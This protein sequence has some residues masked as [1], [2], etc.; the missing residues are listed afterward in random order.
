[1]AVVALR[2]PG[3]RFETRTPAVVS[4]LPRM[5]VAGFVG[6]APR[7][8]V[9]LPIPVEDVARFHDIFGTD[10]ALANDPEKEAI[11]YAELP[12]AV[13]AFFRNGGAR[14]WIVRVAGETA[15]TNRFAM[16][17]LLIAP[18]GAAGIRAA[19][20]LARSPGSWSDTLTVNGTLARRPLALRAVSP[21]SDGPFRAGGLRPGEL[22]QFEFP[23]LP[24][25]VAFRRVRGPRSGPPREVDLPT[26]DAS[27]FRRATRADVGA[28]SP[29]D[30]ITWLPAP[31]AVRWMREIH[32]DPD[33]PL[34]L[35][36]WGVTEDDDFV[37]DLSEADA[38]GL[39]A[40]SWIGVDVAAAPATARPQLLMLVDRV[41]AG[42]GVASPP[43]AAAIRATARAW[44]PLDPAA[45]VLATAGLDARAAVVDLEIWVNDPQGTVRRLA[46]LGF[47]APHT[48]YWGD[49]PDD[50]VAFQEEDERPGRRDR[51]APLLL[52]RVMNPR[53][54]LAPPV[55]LRADLDDPDK[56][57]LFIPLGVPGLL[58]ETF[59]QAA[60]PQS[61]DAL[62]RD[63][64]QAFDPLLFLDKDLE[65]A[66][67]SALM[68][69]AFHIQYV[70]SPSGLDK[71]VGRRLTGIHA[72][73]PVDE[74]SMIAVPDAVQR[75][76]MFDPSVIAPLGAPTL[77]EVSPA[78][79]Q[80]TVRWTPLPDA[81]LSYTLQA[82]FDARF[83]MVARAWDVSSVELT[84]PDDFV[85][86]CGAR[87]FYR[88]RAVSQTLGPGPWSNTGS[89]MVPAEPFTFCA[90]TQ[91]TAP[92]PIS[93]SEER[94]RVVVTWSFPAAIDVV[95]ALERASDPEFASAVVVYTGP[96]HLH[97]VLRGAEPVL[98]FR[99][100]AVVA[101]V[102]SPWSV[103]AIAGVIAHDSYTITPAF[104]Y[105][106]ELVLE[107]H[108]G[109]IRLCAAR[110][111]AHAVLGLPEHFRE[112]SAAEYI[113]KLSS[114]LQIRDPQRVLSYAA[115]FHP[116]IAVRETSGRPDLATWTIPPDGAVCGTIA[117][118]TLK[119]GAWY[120]PANQLLVGALALSP[121][122]SEVALRLLLSRV[123][124]LVQQ[125]RGFVAMD[126]LTLHPGDE[127]GELHVRRLLILLRRLALREGA[128]YVFRSNDDALRRLVERQF[129]QVL[130]DLFVRGAF[131]G[132]RH[133]EGYG[134]VA[135]DTVNTR[136]GRDSGRFVV[137]LRVAPSHPMMF[138]TV[139]LVQE[140]GAWQASEE[141]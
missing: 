55:R 131:A 100:S 43:S 103:T 76:W 45:A 34:P 107:V 10:L 38:R 78:D 130:G 117:A 113:E 56:A 3:I 125:P 121:D 111:D 63:G 122:L 30:D 26:A 80:V 60:L 105:D 7:G 141:P 96:A 128:T 133:E 39:Q 119:N 67:T 31:L 115:A 84:H 137:E 82:S 120:S 57:P 112:D 73:I 114:D 62:T 95:F 36:A 91:P 97:E 19:I 89:A 11:A 102:K 126:E 42:S 15:A 74:V 71:R 81:T 75:P 134:V 50:I 18:L 16:P 66:S 140:G 72:L 79:C 52:E 118:R 2:Q 104:Q 116:W 65:D 54:P 106:D 132:S 108:R 69:D 28:A 46:D 99:V 5:D 4:P 94:G 129:E 40:G 93:L 25:V 29:P 139:R 64:L 98:Y 23:D 59:Y 47:A 1:M 87:V 8:P 44:W 88:V 21:P 68:A 37:L 6:F 138:L 86:A 20:A 41:D 33:P 35:L 27:W 24:G 32:P 13:R 61:A 90:V 12:P 14:C 48:F 49:V 9:N 77:V 83:A 123:N 70:G 51:I 17:G 124:P 101:G 58:E 135:D 110:A 53:F 85:P 127:F 22:V 109:L 136:Q 92:D